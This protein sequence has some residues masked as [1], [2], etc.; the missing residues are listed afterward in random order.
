M[1]FYKTMQ[2]G[3]NVMK[4]MIKDTKDKK[5]KQKYITA[6]ILKNILCLIFCMIFVTIFTKL[7]GN[8][9]SIVGVVTIL[10]VLTFRSSNLDFDVKQSSFTLFGVF[11]IFIIGPNISNLVG[12]IARSV[13]NFIFIMMILIL[14]CHNV[15]LSNQSI[16]VLSYLLLCGYE[17][18]DMNVLI[19]RVIGLATG[20]IIVAI[21]FYIKQRKV[22][23]EH[24]LS[25]II[26]DVDL[27]ND[28]TKWQLKLAF[29]ICTSMLIGELMNLPRTMWIGIAL[30]S[31]IQPNKE[32]V[33]F[34]FK[35]RIIFTF[36]G[37]LLYFIVY[38]SMPVE[39]RSLMGMI[40]GIMVGFSATYQ[41]QVVFNAFGGLTSAI[42]IL[43]LGG[44]L[45]TRIINA[46]FGS[47]YGRFYNEIFDIIHEKITLR[48]KIKQ[49]TT[50]GEF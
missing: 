45:I 3:A 32:V 24:K 31:I 18:S 23:F 14:T 35:N 15:V 40:G 33:E 6:L 44:S 37:C 12:P 38:S 48:N 26:K 1:T 50:N 11:C 41:W 29:G 13:I 34:R 22:K 20:G 47:I 17:V 16:L 43:G 30:M 46:S 2:L 5:L 25:D 8:E 28:R 7:F 36:L 42:P 49:V 27:S 4:P 10:G 9:N 21:I 39:F 19:N